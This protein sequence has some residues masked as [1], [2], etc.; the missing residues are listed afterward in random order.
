MCTCPPGYSMSA[1]RHTCVIVCPQGLIPNKDGKSCEGNMSLLSHKTFDWLYDWCHKSAC[2]F[3]EG[4]MNYTCICD[5]DFLKLCMAI[6][7][8]NKHV[9]LNA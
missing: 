8:G 5:C 2:H 4:Y 7:I 6:P 9:A 1:D 3:S